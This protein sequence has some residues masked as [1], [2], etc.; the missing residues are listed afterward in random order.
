MSLSLF[1][2]L[3]SEV[4]MYCQKRA[5]S[6]GDIEG[7]LEE[8]GMHHG[9]RLLELL[10]HR[11]RGLRRETRVLGALSFVHTHVWKAL[12]GRAAD[13]LEKCTQAEDEYM[14]ADHDLLVNRFISVPKDMGSLNCGAYVAGVVRGVLEGAGFPARV[15]A[16][17]VPVGGEGGAGAGTGAAPGGEPG[18][19]PRPKTV[20]L[21]KFAQ[22]VL[23][24]EQRLG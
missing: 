6:V 11:E 13:S 19:E 17:F 4:V 18:L 12:F 7:R 2:F 15:T 9:V 24:R 21:I 20:I 16:H 23:D 14:I 5:S 3:F 1:A 10:A 8:M 22:E